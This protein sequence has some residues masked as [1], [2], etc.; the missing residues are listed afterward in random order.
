M[1]SHPQFNEIGTK[2]LASNSGINKELM[3]D[4]SIHRLQ[5]GEELLIEEQDVETAILLLQG[6]IEF[7]Y[8]QNLY[9]VSRESVFSQ[10]PTCLHLCS[11]TTVIVMAMDNAEIL[12]QSAYN[13]HEFRPRLYLPQDIKTTTIQESGQETAEK[14]IFTIFDYYNAPYSNMVLGEMIVPDGKWSESS[15]YLHSHPELNYYEYASKEGFGACFTE[16]KVYYINDGSCCMFQNPQ[17]SIL[18][19]APSHKMYCYWTVRHLENNPW[20]ESRG[21]QDATTTQ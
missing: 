3:M 1:F 13:N 19:T 20:R 17:S 16:D 8:D 7:E 15:P 5:K 6:K 18:A 9:Q 11:G 2:I 21:K 14:N 4:I 12:V 10:L